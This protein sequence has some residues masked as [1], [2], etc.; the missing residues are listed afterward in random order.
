VGISTTIPS[1]PEDVLAC[2]Y[3]EIG[4][5]RI[6]EYRKHDDSMKKSSWKLGTVAEIPT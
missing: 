5:M 4:P 6:K 2:Y 1:V 3:G